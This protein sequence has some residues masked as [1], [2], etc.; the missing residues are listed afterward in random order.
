MSIEY[1]G[2]HIVLTYVGLIEYR[3]KRINGLVE[4]A[5]LEI[6]GNGNCLL[7]VLVTYVFHDDIDSDES[8]FNAIGYGCLILS[9]LILSLTNGRSMPI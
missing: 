5:V 7:L 8:L 1:E 9:F 2:W 4:H 3:E 6:I